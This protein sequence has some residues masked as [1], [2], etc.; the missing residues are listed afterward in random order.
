MT[1]TYIETKLIRLNEIKLN[2]FYTVTTSDSHNSVGRRSLEGN[3]RSAGQ[4]AYVGPSRTVQCSEYSVIYLVSWT[5]CT[6]F[7]FS[8]SVL[9]IYFNII[10]TSLKPPPPMWFRFWLKCFRV[11]I[12]LASMSAICPAPLFS[13]YFIMVVILI[14]GEGLLPLYGVFSTPSYFFTLESKAKLSP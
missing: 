14:F 9:T 11:C 3:C 13:L 6:Q 12:Y 5:N 10:V 4:F 7:T 2:D 8:Y 1:S